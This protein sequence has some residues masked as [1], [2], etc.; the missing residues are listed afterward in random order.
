MMTKQQIVI[1]GG[2]KGIGLAVAKA[3][4]TLGARVLAVSRTR[5]KLEAARDAV[6]G[7]E[8]RAA[9]INN[10]ASI[11]ELFSELLTV[12]IALSLRER[13]GLRPQ[14]RSRLVGVGL[15]NFCDPEDASA[16]SAL[17]R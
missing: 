10:T 15:S 14:Q 5:A 13:V 4:R 6:S 17:F 3:A 12:D 1:I 16:Q 2:S 11:Q 9:D 8:I 7:L